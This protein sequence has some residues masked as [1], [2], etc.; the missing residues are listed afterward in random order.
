MSL[1][2]RVINVKSLIS[3]FFRVVLEFILI[4]IA[5]LIRLCNLSL[6]AQ[7]CFMDRLHQIPM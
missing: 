3:K 1:T 5:I 7:R 2:R 4:N 6:N